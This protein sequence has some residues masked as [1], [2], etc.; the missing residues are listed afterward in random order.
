VW[1]EG[2]VTRVT[3]DGSTSVRL[4]T[5]EFEFGLPASKIKPAAV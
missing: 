3:S 5:G 4:D 1:V 2:T